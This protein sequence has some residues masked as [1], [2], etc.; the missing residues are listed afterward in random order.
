MLTHKQVAQLHPL[1][2]YAITKKMPE[3]VLFHQFSI[4]ENNYIRVTSAVSPELFMQLVP[5]YYFSN[6]P[7]SESKDILQ[8][9]S[10]HLPTTAM[11]KDQDVCD[12]C[13]DATEQR[14][15]VQ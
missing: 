6:L 13:P 14:C 3:W 15:T 7:P 9:A 11:D 4:S 5:Q 10:G 12:K 8:Q 1:S 2:S